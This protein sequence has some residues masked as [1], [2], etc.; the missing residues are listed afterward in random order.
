MSFANSE[1][2]TP[3]LVTWMT[4][5]SFHCLIA[6]ARISRTM[7]NNNDENGHPCLVPDHRGKAFSF[8]TLRM[9][10]AVGFSY[11]AFIMLR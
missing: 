2:V 11:Q 8:S 1:S 9:I 5:I 4:F 10:L 3:S 6:E 7:L